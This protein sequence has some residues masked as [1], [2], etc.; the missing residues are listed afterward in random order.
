MRAALS[1]LLVST[2]SAL[3]W[4]CG[5]SAG[6]G[7]ISLYPD[8]PRPLSELSVIQV[9]RTHPTRGHPTIDV[10]KISLVGDSTT[11]I[12][13]PRAGG[14]GWAVPSHF[15]G[16]PDPGQRNAVRNPRELPSR[17][18]VLPGQYLI[19]FLYM[20]AVDHL[21]WTH[22]RTTEEMTLLECRPGVTYLLKGGLRE[23]G[24]GWVLT[25][26]ERESGRAG[27]ER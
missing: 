14:R 23:V 10:R 2:V 11:V 25:V 5:G 7:P 9:V 20:P 16:L 1:I 19:E 3:P 13:Q 8:P 18:E 15:G 6:P 27:G 4:G 21:G 26:T 12:F 24:E 22:Q 17:F